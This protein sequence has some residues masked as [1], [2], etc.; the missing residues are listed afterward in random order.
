MQKSGK[1]NKQILKKSKFTMSVELGKIKTDKANRLARC[2]ETDGWR[3]EKEEGAME[4]AVKDARRAKK[5]IDHKK[6]RRR[7]YNHRYLYLLII[8][9][10]LALIVFSYFPM[11]GIQLAFKEFKYNLG[12]WGSPWAGWENFEKIFKNPDFWNAFKNTLIISFG[13]IITGFPVPI[14][15]ALLLNELKST[16]FKKVS[17]TVMY[18]PYFVSWIVMAGLISNIFSIN[19]GIYGKVFQ[20]FGVEP[21]MILGNPDYFR[22]LIYLSSIWKGAGWG[23]IIYL[24]ALSGVDPSL[25]ESARLD[26]ANRFQQVWY[27]TLPCLTFA[28]SVNLILDIGGVMNAGFDQIFNLYSAGTYGVGDVLDTYVYRLGIADGKFEMSTAVGLFKSVINCILL[29]VANKSAKLL[30]QEGLY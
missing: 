6:L 13:K 29:L 3:E 16:K 25:Y 26:G 18:L 19:T 1:K 27:I 20:S 10:M 8:P 9:G 14:V 24:A 21:T 22:P 17:Q 28:I 11:Y 15:L 7:I 23:T 5:K 4:A 12:I 2:T 30:G